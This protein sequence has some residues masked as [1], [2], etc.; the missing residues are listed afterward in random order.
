MRRSDRGRSTARTYAVHAIVVSAAVTHAG[1]QDATLTVSPLFSSH[2]VLQRDEPIHFW[3][4]SEPG[5]SVTGTFARATFETAADDSGRWRATIDPLPAGGPHVLYLTSGDESLR[6]NNI[7]I[8]D[9]WL[10]SGQSNMGWRLEQ[11]DLGEQFIDAAGNAQLR[12]LQANRRTSHEPIDVVDSRGWRPDAPSYVPRFSAVGYHFGRIV[13]E[14]TGVPIGLIESTWGGTPAEAWTPEPTLR[15]NTDWAQPLLDK[16]PAYDVSPQELEAQ[17]AAFEA[18]HADYIAGILEA[19]AGLPAG[20]HTPQL[21]DSGWQT[22]GAPGFWEPII[23]S[24]DGI[25]WLR[26]TITLSA[27]QAQAG[28]TLF[29]GMVEEYD[30]TYVNGVRIGSMNYPSPGAGRREREYTIEPG[31]LSPGENTIA[32]RVVDTRTAG[33]FGSPPG[34]MRLATP[35][36][37]VSLDGQWRIRISH[38]ARDDGGFPLEGTRM[39]T[40]AR[41]QLRPAAL[42]NGMLHQFV[43]MPIKGVIWYQGESN[44]GRAEQYAE[45]FPAM[46]RSWRDAWRASDMAAAD[47]P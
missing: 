41:Q 42:Y 4:T 24:V 21:D 1:A 22:I 40:A 47:F 33:G 34:T 28:G 3:G 30:D 13:Q 27:D 37:D 14:E 11:T 20:W 18:K 29:L 5:A 43:G 16:L 8:G 46:I 6:S 32:I 17:I 12:L 36:G 7:L 45:L 19:E 44:N 38:N 39:V 2:A 9:I 23:G 35:D 25:V 31:I 10:C 26:R 15:D